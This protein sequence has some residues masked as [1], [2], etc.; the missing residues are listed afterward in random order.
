MLCY[1]IDLEKHGGLY[2]L[3]SHINHTC[4]ANISVRHLDQQISL[5]KIT[6]KTLR[7]IITGEEL[8]ITYVDPTFGVKARRERLLEW[9][10]GVCRCERCCVEETRD[11]DKKDD[12][13]EDMIRELKAGLGVI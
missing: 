2:P 11:D 10:F 9:G 13:N 1:L 4:T 5:S 7:P 6:I 8:C 12:E 3:H